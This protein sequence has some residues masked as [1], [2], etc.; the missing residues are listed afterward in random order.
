MESGNRRRPSGSALLGDLRTLRVAVLHPD[1]SDGLHLIQQLQRIGCQTQAFWPPPPVLPDV[2]DVV[3]IA[4]RPDVIHRDMTWRTP[5][6]RAAVIAIVTYE[7]PTIVQTV[8][9]LGAH[10]VMP[11]PVRSFGV[12]STLVVARGVQHEMANQ[13]KQIRKLET[14]LA[15]QRRLADAKAV[16]MQQ[17]CISEDA[18]YDLIRAQA[19][20]KRMSMDEIATA[21]INANEILN[22][23]KT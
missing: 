10:A 7:N 8:L 9:E 15:G 12:L 19:M 23:G 21:I 11:S 17:R 4:V 5:E 1:D 20:A 13:T 2:T 3:F 16:L 18:A 14:K 6:M 22:L